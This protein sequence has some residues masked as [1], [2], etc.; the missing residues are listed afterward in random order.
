MN[1]EDVRLISYLKDFEPVLV[2]DI[3]ANEGESVKRFQA[4]WPGVQMVCF[5][6]RRAAFEKLGNVADGFE[7]VQ[8]LRL[9]LGAES[10]PVEMREVL[11]KH[12]WGGRS[13]MLDHHVLPDHC[14][15]ARMLVH[16]YRL[17]DIN[18]LSEPETDEM[19]IKID[20]EGYA[21]HVIDGGLKTISRAR[22]C[23]IE[24]NLNDKYIRDQTMHTD[25]H[26]RMLALG[27]TYSGVTREVRTACPLWQDELY[28][29][30]IA[31]PSA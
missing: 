6:P 17:D 24:V 10:G 30:E 4:L 13:T 26:S 23:L 19:F 25:V 21:K 9:A 7:G 8:I 11:D 18:V 20:V 1:T 16:M 14:S 28:I 12:G 29:K 27:F 31:G 22:A 2:L 15:T 5:E 3:G